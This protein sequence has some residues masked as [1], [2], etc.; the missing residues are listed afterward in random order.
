ML[1]E[2]VRINNRKVGV[3]VGIKPDDSEHFFVG[4]SRC[5]PQDK[6]DP[7][8]GTKIALSRAVKWH[9]RNLTPDGLEDILD[10]FTAPMRFEFWSFV[11][12][13][14]KY[15]KDANPPTYLE[16]TI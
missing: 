6:F 3:L 12:R 2:Y 5:A 14:R 8:Y 15:F 7:S 10:T 11:N 1:K 13:C 16:K 9:D 4:M